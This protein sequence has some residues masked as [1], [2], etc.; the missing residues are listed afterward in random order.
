MILANCSLTEVIYFAAFAFTVLCACSILVRNQTIFCLCFVLVFFK[1]G[2]QG[3][4]VS[5]LDF[6]SS[7]SG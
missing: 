7:V 1:T 2:R 4:A 3:F 6:G 5:P